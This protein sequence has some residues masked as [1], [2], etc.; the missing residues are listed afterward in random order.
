[1]HAG[2][3][4]NANIVAVIVLLAIA[5]FWGWSWRM[6]RLPFGLSATAEVGEA[7]EHGEGG[8]RNDEA[9]NVDHDED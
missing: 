5:G 3:P 4:S 7:G 9:G 6:Q 2:I 1:M 8:K